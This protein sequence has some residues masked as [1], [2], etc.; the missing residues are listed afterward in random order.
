M[1]EGNTARL[2]GRATARGGARR[3]GASRRARGQGG[4]SERPLKRACSGGAGVAT[5]T[6]PPGLGASGFPH[7]ER[8]SASSGQAPR[9]CGFLSPNLGGPT[10]CQRPWVW[11]LPHR[12]WGRGPS[13]SV[14]P[15][16]P[17]SPPQ[18]SPG[19]KAAAPSPSVKCCHPEG[20]KQWVKGWVG[21]FGETGRGTI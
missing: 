18:T 1:Q 7:T 2:G 13:E 10:G 4:P 20:P 8:I 21:G 19:L 14:R 17:P 12:P 9:G 16:P 15:P 6:S 3:A 5:Y 11:G